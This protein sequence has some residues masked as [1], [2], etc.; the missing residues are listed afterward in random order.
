MK[1]LEF[2]RQYVKE[3]L[4]L[5]HDLSF[6]DTTEIPVKTSSILSCFLK[7][8]WQISFFVAVNFIWRVSEKRT[9]RSVVVIV[10]YFFKNFYECLFVGSPRRIILLR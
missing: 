5:S 10:N 6:I 1:S 2:E 8:T 4:E 7:V 3:R 9:M